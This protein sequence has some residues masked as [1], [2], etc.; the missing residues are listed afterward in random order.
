MSGGVGPTA[1]ISLP[2]D[3]HPIEKHA[4]NLVTTPNLSEKYPQK[5]PKA[6]F[7][8]LRQLNCLAIMIVLAASGLVSVEEIAIVFFSMIYIIF[9]SKYVFPNYNP[10][11]QHPVFD[12]N[13]KILGSYILFAGVIGL[14]L[15]I[16]YIFHGVLKG[17]KD[18]IKAAVPHV[19]VL[20]SQVF[21]EGVSAADRFSIPIRVFIPVFFNSYRLLTIRVW[22]ENDFMNVGERRCGDGCSSFGRLR[23]GRVLAVANAVLWTYNLFGFLLPVFLPRAFKRYYYDANISNN[24]N[25]KED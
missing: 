10:S 22:M 24:S 17:D 9:L 11:K 23:M 20:A 13:S 15:P 3:E 5:T 14:F 6:F 7:I 4:H 12:P 1:D 21:M 25:N 16:L 8:T 18:G 2:K 19:F